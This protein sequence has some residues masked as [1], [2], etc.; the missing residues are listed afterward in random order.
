[1]ELKDIIVLLTNSPRYFNPTL[2]D[3]V[4][5]TNDVAQDIIKELKVRHRRKSTVVGAKPE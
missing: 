4:V 1:M 3:T 2:G 5:I